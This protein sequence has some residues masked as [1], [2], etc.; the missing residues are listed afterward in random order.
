MLLILL[1]QTL[2]VTLYVQQEYPDETCVAVAVVVACDVVQLVTTVM[3][4]P[5]VGYGQPVM[6][7][8]CRMEMGILVRAETMG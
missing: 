8:V 6:V 3:G 2:R 5:A 7:R 1:P 4:L